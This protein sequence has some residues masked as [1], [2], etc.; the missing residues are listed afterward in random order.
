MAADA[1]GSAIENGGW[2]P[3][4]GLIVHLIESLVERGSETAD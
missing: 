3:Y 2:M 4:N 1:H